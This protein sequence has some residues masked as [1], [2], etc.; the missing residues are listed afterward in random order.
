MILVDS[1]VLV[2]LVNRGHPRHRSCVAT[3]RELRQPLATVWPVLG[4][5]L[6]ST[7]WSPAAQ[8]AI[9]EMVARGALRLLPLGQEDA[10]RLQGLLTRTG[11]RRAAPS[12][13]H[14]A[15]AHVASRDGV[16]TAFTLAP[17]ALRSAGRKA[18]RTIPR[19]LRRRA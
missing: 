18:L 14:A 5:A 6:T 15:L 2:A 9:L 3:L 10:T 7:T 8:A 17:A 11:R 4:D 19:A 13:A 1:D 16:G 12:L